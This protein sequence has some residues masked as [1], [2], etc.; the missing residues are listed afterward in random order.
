[1]YFSQLWGLSIKPIFCTCFSGLAGWHLEVPILLRKLLLLQLQCLKLLQMA[2]AVGCEAQEVQGQ[3]VSVMNPFDTICKRTASEWASSK[4]L[5]PIRDH[6][7]HSYQ[8]W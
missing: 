4:L 7:E 1:M 8:M 3:V 6:K 5:G 2:A